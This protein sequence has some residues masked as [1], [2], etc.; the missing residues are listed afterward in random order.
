MPCAR[1]SAA[2]REE[3]VSD[4]DPWVSL[5]TA[6]DQISA[7]MLIEALRDAGIPARI[8]PGD[9]QSF[10]GLSNRP[11]RVLVDRSRLADAEQI[12]R[13]AGIWPE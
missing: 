3:S 2:A 1:P 7:E 12:R 4:D 5:A 11:C 13:D 9:V 6:P 10:L 8:S